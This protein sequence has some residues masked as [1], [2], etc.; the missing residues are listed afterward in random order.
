MKKILNL[1]ILIFLFSKCSSNNTDEITKDVCSSNTNSPTEESFHIENQIDLEN[2]STLGYTKINNT[3]SISKSDDLSSLKCLEYIKTLRL[4]QNTFENLNGLD[5]IKEIETLHII[6]CNNLKTLNGLNNLE[7]VSEI[8]IENN[9]SLQNFTGLN[10]VKKINH[11]TLEYNSKIQNFEGLESLKS[12]SSLNIYEN[13]NLRNFEGLYS[14]KRN[15]TNDNFGSKSNRFYIAQNNNLESLSGLDNIYGNLHSS[16]FITQC[17][18]LT[19]LGNFDNIINTSDIYIS[20]CKSLKAFDGF[21]DTMQIKSLVISYCESIEYINAP[22]IFRIGYLNIG[23][24]P[25]LNS[26]K[27]LKT[28]N[29]IYSSSGDFSLQLENNP[30]LKTLEGFENLSYVEKIVDIN[31]FS[32]NDLENTCAL[33]LLIKNNL[34]N[35]TT[36][37]IN[38]QSKCGGYGYL[39]MRFNEICN[40]NK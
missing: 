35:G 27:G 20:F 33:S 31:I 25:N 13:N 4:N 10:K 39:I 29:S 19:S 5:R 16:L 17:P 40:C 12:I 34:Y 26:L 24:N 6:G 3:L 7:N 2:F 9:S 18:K 23:D 21:Y 30:K 22:K 28:L 38:I 15:H 36:S 32:R 37:K 14:L 8:I 11:L 1:T